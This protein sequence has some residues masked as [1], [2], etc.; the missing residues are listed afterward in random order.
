MALG[1]RPGE[2]VIT[3]AYSFFAT[4]GA[5]SRLGAVPLFADIDPATFN[6]SPD[7]VM[8]ILQREHERKI[9]ALIPVHLFGQCA[10]MDVLRKIA[11]AHHL[12]IIEDA[13]QALGAK[14]RGESAGAMG[15]IGCFSFF[16]SKNLGCF[17]DG[18]MCVTGDEGL[19][20]RLRV[21]RTH[22]SAQKYYHDEI[23]INSRLDEIQACILNIKFRT[24]N[25]AN[26]KRIQHAEYYE[27]LIGQAGLTD[28]IRTPV[29]MENNR[30]VY[31]QYVILAQDRDKLK[32]NLDAAGVG[33]AIY[34]PVILPR[35]RCYA[36]HPQDQEQFPHAQ[37]AADSSLALPMF[38]EL[39]SSQQE[40]VVEK[41]HQFYRA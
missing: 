19:A 30:H 33:N 8:Q 36:G 29:R 9:R 38:P 17:G 39:T 1:L 41:M 13:A 2:A 32:N 40:Y 16:P 18:G 6:I 26:Q 25:D 20:R 37:R 23:G 14:F 10:D 35:Q 5:V 4:A 7:S 27:K 28:K 24:L 11:S 15:T 3:T 22:G 34:Y 31:H 12:A 21:L